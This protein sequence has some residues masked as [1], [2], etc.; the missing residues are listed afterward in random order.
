MT[1]FTYLFTNI[2]IEKNKKVHVQK[3]R[4]HESAVAAYL[5][6]GT[7]ETFLNYREIQ[8]NDE[9]PQGA[10]ITP[11]PYELHSPFLPFSFSSDVDFMLDANIPSGFMPAPKKKFP[12]D[13][14]AKFNQSMSPDPSAVDHK[15]F[16]NLVMSQT[17]TP[18]Q[19]SA[20]DSLSTQDSAQDSAQD[21]LSTQKIIIMGADEKNFDASKYTDKEH[22]DK[23]GNPVLRKEYEN[24]T[25]YSKNRVENDVGKPYGTLTFE[26]NEKNKS[27]KL[28]PTNIQAESISVV[29]FF[30]ID[31]FIMK[32]R[33]KSGQPGLME[34]IASE[35]ECKFTFEAVYRILEPGGIVFFSTKSDGKVENRINDLMEKKLYVYSKN[36][37]EL[38]SKEVAAHVRNYPI[39][40]DIYKYNETQK[41]VDWGYR[42]FQKE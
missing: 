5:A 4:P 3:M 22:L 29:I 13:I 34:Y 10:L 24:Y 27:I 32:E 28:L 18:L 26:R 11:N 36:F 17:F 1:R 2:T 14:F 38:E 30:D 12:E 8:E 35:A 39:E 25:F 6:K 42:A 15:L 33:P 23:D 40:K 9:N 19:D 21:F 20:Q 31:R 7:V 37:T 41:H 16:P